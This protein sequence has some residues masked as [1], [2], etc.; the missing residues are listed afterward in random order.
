[1]NAPSRPG[2]AYEVV[3]GSHYEMTPDHFRSGVIVT[4][5][6]TGISYM[7]GETHTGLRTRTA[8]HT[9]LCSSCDGVIEDGCCHA[10]QLYHEDLADT[11]LTEVHGDPFLKSRRAA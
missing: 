6:L 10:C 5:A 7:V 9:P 3:R 4:D 8:L 11:S 1:M 2:V